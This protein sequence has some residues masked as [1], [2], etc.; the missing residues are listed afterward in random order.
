MLKSIKPIMLIWLD[1][2]TEEDGWNAIS[3]YTGETDIEDFV[4]YTLGFLVHE[5]SKTIKVAMSVDNH[6]H[7]NQV[8]NIYK[9]DVI[10]RSN[11]RVGKD[12]IKLA[13]KQQKE[14]V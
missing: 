7:C 6:E 10:Y 3:K 5:D 9:S 1:H 13:I 14:G 4:V 2:H 11:P 8:L 12:K